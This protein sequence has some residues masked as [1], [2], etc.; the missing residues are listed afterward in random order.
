MNEQLYIWERLKNTDKPIILYGTGNGA[1]KIL[2][3]F[4]KLNININEIV[5]SDDFCRNQNFRGY[6]VKPLTPT[7]KLYKDFILVLAFATQIPD[8]IEKIYKLEKEFNLLCPYTPVFGN[9]I[10]TLDFYKKN[11]EDIKKARKLMQDNISLSVFDNYLNFIMYGKLDYIKACE[12]PKEEAFYNILKLCDHE[13][14]ADLGA[15]KG[16][17]IQEIFDMCSGYEN[18]YAFEP[19][20][21]TFKKLEVFTKNLPNIYNFN[22]GIWNEN[23]TLLFENNADRSSTLN[24]KKGTPTDVV[25]LDNIIKNKK[26]TYIKMDIE[27]AEFEGLNGSKN[28]LK[29]QKPKLNIAVYHRNEDFFKLPLL[30]KEINPEYKIYMRH[31]PYIPFWD[32]NIYCV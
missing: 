9:D 26:I 8:L 21:K 23:K 1:D 24:D 10:F 4:E 30:I 3:E 32:T 5:A 14:I 15:Y 12:T 31:H 11:L 27:G 18:I 22:Y 16:D 19:D 6:T 7:L 13:H 17:T 2:N 25:A 29:K 20:I 28:I